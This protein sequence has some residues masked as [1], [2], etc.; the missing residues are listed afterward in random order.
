MPSRIGPPQIAPLRLRGSIIVDTYRGKVR[1]RSWKGKL[2]RPLH[3]HTTYMNAW[4][5]DAC[6]KIKYADARAVDFAIQTA[7]GTGLYPR[8][9]LMASMAGGLVDIDLPDGTPI[10][11]KRQGL[12]PVSFQGARL[13][14][15]AN[16]AIAAST[17]T[18]LTWQT[19]VIDTIG[20][21]DPVNPTRI[22]IPPGVN[23][24]RFT[25]GTRATVS[26]ATLANTYVVKT[27]S[28]TVAEQNINS[29][30]WCGTT[31]DTGPIPVAEGDIFRMGIVV[32][33]ARN[34]GFTPATF[35]ACEI[36]DADY[37]NV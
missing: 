5:S 29:C 16:Q 6:R 12:F 30:Q 27:G 10:T 32:A 17:P 37:P 15:N 7:K 35:F 3:P 25:G 31:I 36:L 1:V 28:T 8:D 13:Q 18:D 21:F 24:V 34:M 4:F 14:K 11:Y 22:T 19:V 9:I 2:K 33:N 23:V 26:T 20:M